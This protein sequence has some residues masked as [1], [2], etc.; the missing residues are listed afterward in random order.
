MSK[1]TKLFGTVVGTVLGLTAGTWIA[2]KL[3]YST[4]H[5]LQSNEDKVLPLNQYQGVTHQK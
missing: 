4:N 3:F 5:Q 1:K 2:N